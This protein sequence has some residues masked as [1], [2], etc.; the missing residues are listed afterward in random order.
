MRIYT[1][2]GDDGTTGLYYGGRVGKDD[3]GPEAYGTVDEAVSA[4]GTARAAADGEMA[5]RIL[6][7]QRQFFVVAA[8]LATDP[9]NLDKLEPGVSRC[10]P[11]MVAVLEES[12]D[13]IVADVGLPTEFVVPGG[14]AVAAALDLA[15]TVV[16]RA[17]RRAVAHLEGIG[18]SQV[19]PFLNRAADYLYV[20]A[21]AAEGTWEPSRDREERP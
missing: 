18:S 16:R 11:E 3:T 13:R 4:L 8:E 7:L 10:T 6:D 9:A 5:A 17:E 2:K 19:V 20:L 12:I 15:R 1:R 21:R 14:T